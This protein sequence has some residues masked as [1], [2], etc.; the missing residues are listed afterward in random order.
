MRSMIYQFNVTQMKYA[1]QAPEIHSF[2]QEVPH[3][4]RLAE[5]SPGFV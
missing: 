1:K 2:F 4:Q 5:A 3:L